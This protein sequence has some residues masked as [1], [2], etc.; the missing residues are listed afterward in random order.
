MID[1]VKNWRPQVLLLVSDPVRQLNLIQFTNN[2]K[3][4][5]LYVLGHAYVTDETRPTSYQDKMVT[6][7]RDYPIWLEIIDW[8]RIKS[9]VEM[10][11]SSN[12]YYGA[13]NLIMVS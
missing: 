9:F 13:M 11:I 8:L 3:K 5:G 1:H 2:L 4:G 12:L 6:Y 7:K 10:T